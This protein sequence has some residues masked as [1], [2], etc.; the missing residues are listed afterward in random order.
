MLRNGIIINLFTTSSLNWGR[1]WRDMLHRRAKNSLV[2]GAG[3]RWKIY[4]KNN[5]KKLT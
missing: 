5:F 1:N 2:F 3:L 4:V